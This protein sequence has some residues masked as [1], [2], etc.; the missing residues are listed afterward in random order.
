M[1]GD[2]TWTPGQLP[3]G[4]LPPADDGETLA[5]LLGDAAELIDHLSAAASRLGAPDRPELFGA[6]VDWQD[7]VR[8]WIV[9]NTAVQ[10]AAQAVRLAEYRQLVQAALA[11]LAGRPGLGWTRLDPG[12][13][14][15]YLVVRDN[16][17]LG[18][19]HPARTWFAGNGRI[20][21]RTWRATPTDGPTTQLGPF[22]SIRKAA[23]ALDAHAARA[24]HEP[25][26]SA[27]HGRVAPIPQESA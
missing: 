8:R 4:D 23:E 16:R 1:S 5:R 24:R 18:T 9:E 6:L 25:T 3:K 11:R 27:H 14:S 10:E 19:V 20:R 17:E 13:S 21:R 26:L 2:T 12:Q 15:L 7:E 22:P